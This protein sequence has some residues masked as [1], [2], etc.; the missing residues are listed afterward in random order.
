MLIVTSLRSRCHFH[1][2]CP[3]PYCHPPCAASMPP[4]SRWADAAH[5]LDLSGVNGKV[6]GYSWGF[7]F[8]CITVL[9][10]SSWLCCLSS[11]FF[12][13]CSCQPEN[14]VVEKPVRVMR[15][16]VHKPCLQ[17]ALPCSCYRQCRLH[18][19]LIPVRSSAQLLYFGSMCSSACRVDLNRYTHE[20]N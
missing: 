18:S 5:A 9:S 4:S 6:H 8:G 1:V 19:A 17:T 3:F 14:L 16:F 7:P 2:S 11:R 12:G 13:E 20:K 15:V 10:G